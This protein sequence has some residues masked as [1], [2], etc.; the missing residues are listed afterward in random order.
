MTLGTRSWRKDDGVCG[1]K[2]EEVGVA[3]GRAVLQPAGAEQGKESCP[4]GRRTGFWEMMQSRLWVFHSETS[5]PLEG[6]SERG[7]VVYTEQGISVGWTEVQS[8]EVPQLK[9]EN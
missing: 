6:Q 2:Q 7:P 8:T 1:E 3:T 9:G 4:W 5:W